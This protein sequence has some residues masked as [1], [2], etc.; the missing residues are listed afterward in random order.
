M[1]WL[2][3]LNDCAEIDKMLNASIK[4]LATIHY[5]LS[6][7]LRICMALATLCPAGPAVRTLQADP[8]V[9]FS[10]RTR[11]LGIDFRHQRGASAQKHLV[12][13]MGSGCA[14]LDYD[15]DGR[16]DVLLINGGRTPDSPPFVPR[17]HALYRNRGGGRLEEVTREAGLDLPAGYGMGV[18]VSDYDNDGDL[19]LYLTHFGPNR[20]YRN[21]GDGTFSDVTGRAGVA[22]AEW[23]TGAAF[24]DYDRDGAPDLYVV[25]YLDATFERN[26]PCE[27]KGIRAYCHPRHFAGVPDRL[28]RNLGDGRFRDVSRSSGILNPEGKGLGVV[29]AD[30]D[31]DGWVDLYVANDSVRNVLLR[32]KGDG[33]FSD[34]T[35]L[36]GTG[37]N[38]QAQAEAGMGVD[39]ADYDGDSLLDIFVTN[40]DLE[41]NALYRYQ[42]NWLFGDERWRSGLARKDRFLL[43]FGAGFLDFDNDGDRDLLVV[44][45][46]V[47]DNI[48]R[49]QP[50]L[51]HPQPDQLFENRGGRFVEHG[52]F[53]RWSSRQPR[54]GRG[55][56]LGD[57]DNDGDIDVLI[58]NCG[59]EPTLLINRVG[60][61]RNWI[62][63]RLTGTDSSRDAVGTRLTL[64]TAEGEQSDQITGG[65]SYLSA[66]D[67]RAHFGLGEA[68]RVEEI[69]IRWPSGKEEVLKDIP[70]NRILHVTEGRPSEFSTVPG[71]RPAAE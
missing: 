40:Y 66:S 5:P 39:A 18:A 63:L 12:E 27:M 58:S 32:N 53:Y 25:N 48:E 42:G 68:A 4:S 21:N 35:L 10:D 14:L 51:S 3:F 67:L 56:A 59:A 70:A 45:G 16:L 64:T 52:P 60:A 57:I 54:V 33:T 26:P 6:T 17:A 69:R 9:P 71:P 30:F 44:N 31:G 43:G 38:S 2:N 20:L 28:Y 19:D 23:S 62:Q 41:T 61:R 49:I 46:H 1:T 22:G 37:Y 29:A 13:T 50:D 65:G 11:A 8:A 24:F 36:S 7:S 34:V 55:A 15:G 47:V